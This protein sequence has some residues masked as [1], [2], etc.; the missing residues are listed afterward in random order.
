M[1]EKFIGGTSIMKRVYIIVEGQTEE[2]FV[3]T[4][5]RN[6]LLHFQINDVRPIKIETSPRT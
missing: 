1:G 4:T 5:L 6:Y 3:N 2:E